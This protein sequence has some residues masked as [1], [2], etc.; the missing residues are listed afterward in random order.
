[1]IAVK[2]LHEDTSHL[3]R[4]WLRVRITDVSMNEFSS[5]LCILCKKLAS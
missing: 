1:M 3:G 5:F 4:R 2:G